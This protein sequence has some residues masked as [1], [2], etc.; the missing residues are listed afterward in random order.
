MLRPP[1]L[2]KICRDV[3]RFEL[4]PSTS[5]LESAGWGSY[6]ACNPSLLVQDGRVRVLVRLVNYT[7]ENGQYVVPDTDG[8]VKTQ[9]LL[10]WL[11][12]EELEELRPV[13]DLDPSRRTPTFVLGYEDLRLFTYDKKLYASA[14]VRDRDRDRCQIA[15]CEWTAEGDIVKATTQEAGRLHEKNWMPI[16]DWHG[17]NVAWLYE[18]ENATVRTADGTLTTNRCSLALDHLR[19]G[20]QV[21]PW[22]NG[23]LA[24]VHETIVMEGWGCRRIYLHRFVR[25][26]AGMRITGVSPAW[27]CEDG[28]YGIE[29]VSTIALRNDELLIGYGLEDREAKVLALAEEDVASIEWVLPDPPIAQELR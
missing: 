8:K 4:T 5:I 1:Y 11:E 13:K 25:F 16:V 29:F 28:H 23:Y 26:D 19:G 3:R 12:G 9:N 14:T 24:V 2:G 6:H 15:L 18:T 22:R 10:G 21:I 7:I 20:S 17:N 27:T